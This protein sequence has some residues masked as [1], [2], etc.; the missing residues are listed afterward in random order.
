MSQPSWHLGKIWNIRNELLGLSI[1][2]SSTFDD[3]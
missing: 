2:P 1:E 3:D